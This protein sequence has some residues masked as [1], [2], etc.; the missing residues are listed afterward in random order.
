MNVGDRV[1][2]AGQS[3]GTVLAWFRGRVVVGWDNGNVSDWMPSALTRVMG[4][5]RVRLSPKATFNG[6]DELPAPSKR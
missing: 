6:K 4:G 3:V 1:S 2:L 5:D